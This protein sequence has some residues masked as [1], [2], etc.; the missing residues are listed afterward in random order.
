MPPLCPQLFGGVGSLYFRTKV[1]NDPLTEVENG[2][3][4]RLDQVGRITYWEE[5]ERLEEVFHKN[6]TVSC[7][8]RKFWYF[9]RDESLDLDTV[10][11]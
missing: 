3:K 4:P 2:Q 11:P 8:T 9:L 10:A 1:G 6:G 7:K 5:T